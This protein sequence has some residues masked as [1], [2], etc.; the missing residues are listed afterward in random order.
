MNIRMQMASVE[1]ISI[2]R[3]RKKINR[4]E[5]YVSIKIRALK[6]SVR[7]LIS[8]SQRKKTSFNFFF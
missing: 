5:G 8:L 2:N 6:F 3:L 1:N 7:N 4:R